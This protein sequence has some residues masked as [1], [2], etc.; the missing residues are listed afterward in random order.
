MWYSAMNKLLQK[1]IVKHNGEDAIFVSASRL[2]GFQECGL[3][4]RLGNIEK[5]P[6][7]GL[8]TEYGALGTAFHTCAEILYTEQKFERRFLLGLWDSAFNEAISDPEIRRMT[9]E[10]KNALKKQ[11]YPLLQTFF[12]T[13]QATNSLK[14]ALYLEKEFKIPY[15]IFDGVRVWVTGKIDQIGRAHV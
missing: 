8:K 6:Q 12:S 13:E 3:K 1:K 7:E 15:K 14:P 9:Q 10:E 11:G 5:I 2:T 4:Y